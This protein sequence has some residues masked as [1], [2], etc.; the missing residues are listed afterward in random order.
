MQW[1]IVSFGLSVKG[2]YEGIG[3]SS[4]SGAGLDCG[5]QIFL[6][7]FIKIG[8]MVRDGVGFLRPYDAPDS[9]KRYDFFKPQIKSGIAFLSD[10]GIKIAL[11]GSKKFEQSGFQYGVGI[12]YSITKYLTLI[13]GLDDNFFSGGFSISL[14]DI[15]IS[16]ALSFDKIDLGYNNTVSLAVLF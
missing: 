6:L 11:S 12:E 13:A 3:E 8:V 1:N 10:T 4:Y 16:Y 7:P 9:E 5:F 2:F 14:W 15:D